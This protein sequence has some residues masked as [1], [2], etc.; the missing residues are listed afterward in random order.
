MALEKLMRNRYLKF[1][2]I[3]F[4]GREVRNMTTLGLIPDI[5]SKY[6]TEEY[7]H[8]YKVDDDRL[9]E[10]ISFELY[11]STDYWDIL[12]KLNDMTS[13]NQLPVN[14]DIIIHRADY[15][16]QEW[17]KKG[18]LLNSVLDEKIIEEKYKEII[19][20]EIAINE[21]FRYIKYVDTADISEL[22]ADLDKLSEENKIN[23]KILIQNED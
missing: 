17:K 10:A 3:D 20:E 14:Y 11:G 23:K 1:E 13:M 19:E 15:K 7:L 12:L 21:K 8:E 22:Q 16:L 2:S 18:K 9:L 6:F 5:P 4:N